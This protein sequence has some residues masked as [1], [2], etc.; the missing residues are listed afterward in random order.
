MT[1]YSTDQATAVLQRGE[2]M[3][4]FS[5]FD[6]IAFLSKYRLAVFKIRLM[7]AYITFNKSLI[8]S[9]LNFE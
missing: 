2:G 1:L 7:V 8:S 4:T 9:S 3:A 6:T 5:R